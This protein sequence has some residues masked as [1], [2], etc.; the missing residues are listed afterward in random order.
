MGD[1]Q[2]PFLIFHW[3][4][5]QVRLQAR[6]NQGLYVLQ[7]RLRNPDALLQ[8]R[9][10]WGTFNRFNQAQNAGVSWRIQHD[11]YSMAFVMPFFAKD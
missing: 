5:A 11:A 4:S 2:T 7:A 10:T 3:A 1:Q 9:Q 8:G 6:W